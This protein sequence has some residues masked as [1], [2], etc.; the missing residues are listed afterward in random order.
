MITK[1]YQVYKCISQ[2][3]NVFLLEEE[4][5]WLSLV[6]YSF[7]HKITLFV[8]ATVKTSSFK[9]TELPLTSIVD[10]WFTAARCLIK[11][12]FTDWI[13][14]LVSSV[15]FMRHNQKFEFRFSL[16]SDNCLTTI[17]SKLSV[18]SMRAVFFLISESFWFCWT[19]KHNALLTKK[20]WHCF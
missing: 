17:L 14:C 4:A 5:T 20:F 15:K 7:R 9:A 19:F 18:L 2:K 16:V 8:H 10:R 3:H 13:Y 1:W 6:A 11:S 12:I